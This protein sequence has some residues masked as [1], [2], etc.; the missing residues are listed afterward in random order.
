MSEIS[1][2]EQQ[3]AKTDT[4]RTTSVSEECLT[5]TKD[6][7][8]RIISLLVREIKLIKVIKINCK[9]V[10]APRNCSVLNCEYYTPEGLP[11]HELAIRDLEVHTNGVHRPQQGGR[12]QEVST[13]MKI[14]KCVKWMLNQNFEAFERDL[15]AW[16]T[17]CQLSQPQQDMLFREMLKETEN[18][19]VKEFYETHL[20]NS[21][22]QDQDMLSLMKKLKDKFGSSTKSEWRKSIEV[23]KEFSWKNEE[24]TERALD[25]LE[26]IRTRW[27]KLKLKDEM[28]KVFIMMFIKEG[29]KEGKL[30]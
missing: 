22:S 19:K 30:D 29:E 12:P 16:Q 18:T 17:N 27:N 21:I 4:T 3:G 11:S 20:M 13:A 6:T 28:D 2:D 26:D 15:E 5:F 23:F 1:L 25:K 7:Q 10:V 8:K 24:N 9:M 14:T